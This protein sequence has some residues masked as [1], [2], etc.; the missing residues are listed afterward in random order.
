MSS[1]AHLKHF[2]TVVA[3]FL[4]WKIRKKR[5]KVGEKIFYSVHIY[6]IYIL[7]RASYRVVVSTGIVTR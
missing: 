5:T 1:A 3:F 2:H 7:L 6:H 4:P